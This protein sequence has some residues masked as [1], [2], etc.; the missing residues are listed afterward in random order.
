MKLIGSRSEYDLWKY[1]M[2]CPEM[3]P[4]TMSKKSLREFLDMDQLHHF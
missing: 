4:F 2:K 1:S 3:F